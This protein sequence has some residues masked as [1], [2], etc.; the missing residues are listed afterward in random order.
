MAES[1]ADLQKKI[2]SQNFQAKATQAAE[3]GALDVALSLY[4]QALALNPFD[5]G[6]RRQF[7]EARVRHFAAKKKGGLGAAFAEMGAQMKMGKAQALIKK[8]QPEEALALAEE[9]L[10]ANPLSPKL[11]ELYF[12]VAQR[13]N[14]PE[15]MLSAMEAL[16][17]S[18]PNDMDLM[19]RLGKTY[20]QAG[21]YGRARDCFQKA[22]Q[23]NPSDLTIQKLLKD[24]MARDT[25]TAG[26]WE[27]NAGKRGGFQALIRDK[28][29]AA[30][31]D[32][33]AK[34]QVTGDDAEAVI[35]EAKAKI[36]KEPK[37]VNYYR[38]LARVYIQNKRFDEALATFADAKK[39]NPSDPELDRNWA[40]TKIKAYEAEIESLNAQGK[41]DEAYDKAVEKAQF[42]FDDLLR[43]V[44]AYPNDLG[45]RYEL[46]VMYYDNE[47]YDDAIQQFQLAQ[48]SPKHRLEALYHLA[49]C[50]KA[51]GQ[52]DMA[53]MQLDAANSQLPT[54]DDLKKR[55][56][57]TLGQ[58]AEEAGDL[59][60]A[61]D[62]Y[63]DVYAA[64][65]GFQDIGERMQR[66]H[67]AKKD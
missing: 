52:P 6:I 18:C 63:K 49:C 7:H 23:A 26:G 57:Y 15:A 22:S 27:E 60:K 9:A 65:I 2:K 5:E 13:T 55:V 50:F 32:R 31:L 66:L 17:S 67:A 33:E 41:D 61:F 46:G 4:R 62:Y 10:D 3:R 47:A 43:R 53:V 14:H 11:N 25:M 19:L 59:D 12:D 56:V 54:M 20:M 38:A 8:N 45:L 30:K 51:K 24:A 42:A 28:E 58:I 64:D 37:N 44:E 48:K 34:A 1:M 16:S 40:D 21:V 39:I 35:A 36:A 29:L